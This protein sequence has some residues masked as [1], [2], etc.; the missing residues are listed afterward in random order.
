VSA[1]KIYPVAYQWKRVAIVIAV[2]AVLASTPKVLGHSLPLA[3]ALTLAYPLVLAAFGF[4][5][6]AERRRLKRLLPAL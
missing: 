4:Y 3:F 5:L 1:H 6:P 2:A